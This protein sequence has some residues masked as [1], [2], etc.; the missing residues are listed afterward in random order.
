MM[1][2]KIKYADYLHFFPYFMVTNI[3]TGIIN[4]AT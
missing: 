1:T 2:I 3:D 4:S